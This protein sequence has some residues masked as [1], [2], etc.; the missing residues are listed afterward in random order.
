[1]VCDGKVVTCTC[2]TCKKIVQVKPAA[3]GFGY[4]ATCPECGKLAYNSGSADGR[5]K[6]K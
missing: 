2:I 4:T 3:Y 6:V 5:E 1:M